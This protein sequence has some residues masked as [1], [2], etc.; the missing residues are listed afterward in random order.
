MKDAYRVQA[1]DPSC[2]S[3]GFIREATKIDD[4]AKTAANHGATHYRV[5]DDQQ[6]IAFDTEYSGVSRKVGGVTVMNGTSTST[7]RTTHQY[8]AEAYRCSP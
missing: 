3:L 7:S 8:I 2:E 6:G 4:L 5:L 1:A